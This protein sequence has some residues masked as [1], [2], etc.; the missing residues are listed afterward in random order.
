LFALAYA[1]KRV[2]VNQKGLKLNGI[3]ELLVYRDDVNILGRSIHTLK[4]NTEVL[5]AAGNEIGL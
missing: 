2:Q 5:V 3:H 4:K 1:I